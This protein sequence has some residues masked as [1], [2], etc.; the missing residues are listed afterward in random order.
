MVP[1]FEADQAR[2]WLRDRGFDV[3][4]A[5]IDRRALVDAGRG[6]EATFG[7]THRADLIAAG[8][9][10]SVVQSGYGLGRSAAEAVVSAKRRFGSEQL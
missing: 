9:A 8:R 5:E 3:V 2:A 6:G 10:D 4:V 1:D 7:W